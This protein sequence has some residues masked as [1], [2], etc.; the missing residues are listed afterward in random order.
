MA[1]HE[2]AYPVAPGR[3]TLEMQAE[4]DRLA[5]L[6]PEA[7]DFTCPP[8]EAARQADEAINAVWNI[9]QPEVAMVRHLQI[10]ADIS[11]QAAACEAVVYTPADAGEGL[12]F[13]VHGGGWAFCNLATHERFMRVL[14]NEARKTVVGVHY[15]PAPEN[16]FPAGLNDVVS[17]FRHVLSARSALGLPGGPVVMAGDSA[18]ANLALAAMLHELE[19]G[20]EGPV[21]ALL[22]YGVFGADFETPS[23]KA[24]ADGHMLT[25]AIMRQIW[26][27]YIPSEVARR[28][29]LAAPLMATDEQLRALPPLF[30]LVA[31]ID[32]LASDTYNLKKRLDALG[33]SDVLWVEPGVVHG[34][35]QMTAVLE[36]ARRATGQAAAAA[37]RFIAAAAHAGSAGDCA[38]DLAEDHVET[39]FAELRASLDARTR[40]REGR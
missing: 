35:L 20:R 33:R 37:K 38:G 14:C 18:G 34:F 31:E 11:L 4:M 9:D 21:G 15:R 8:D 39:T 16:P 29:P 24:Y 32:P 36:A 17:A 27:W 3:Y 6:A 28:N 19:A 23:Y 22:F 30:L 5:K 2:E 40:G 26:D 25:E 1:N 12:I 10:P 13:F 7:V